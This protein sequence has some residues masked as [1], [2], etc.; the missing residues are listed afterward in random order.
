MLVGL[1]P[2]LSWLSYLIAQGRWAGAVRLRDP[3]QPGRRGSSGAHVARRRRRR[4]GGPA[5]PGLRLARSAPARG[6]HARS[7]SPPWCWDSWL[8]PRGSRA[9]GLRPARCPPA[10]ASRPDD[11][12]PRRTLLWV[13]A[14]IIA[15]WPIRHLVLWL[16]PRQAR[17]F[18]T[19]ELAAATTQADPP[20]VSAII[21]AKD[22]E[23][24]L[25]DCLPRSAARRTRTSRSSSSTTAAPTGPARSPA[26]SRRATRGSAS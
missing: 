4:P 9:R 1:D 17:Q 23:A 20:L 5:G 2:D 19:P 13:Y 8:Y 16:H 22:E 15:I 11:A 6:R 12:R 25:A 18:L 3:R 10:R 24:T 21:P 7:G 26:S 14:A